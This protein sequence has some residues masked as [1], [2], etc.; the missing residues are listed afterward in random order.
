M[1]L[2][3]QI[4]GAAI[5]DIASLYIEINR[6]FMAGE[7]WQLG[8]SLDALDDLL[9]G[10]YGALRGH[11][12]AT[13][14]WRES[15]HSRTALGRDTTRA[16]LLAKLERPAAFNTDALV[17]QLAALDHGEGQTYFEIVLEIFAAHPNITLVMA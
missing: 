7:S 17:R 5:T 15:N 4:D 9:Y 3:L 14:V 16:W 6:V 1:S 2:S 11:A 8:P 10:G 12:T 13:V